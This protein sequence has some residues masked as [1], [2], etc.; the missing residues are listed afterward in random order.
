MFFNQ[1][2]GIIGLIFLGL[3]FL[4]LALSLYIVPLKDFFFIKYEKIKLSFCDAKANPTLTVKFLFK[5]RTTS[6]NKPDA[7]IARWVRVLKSGKLLYSCEGCLS[8]DS[9]VALDTEKS[10]F[11]LAT[12]VSDD[13]F[14]VVP[15][16]HS[17]FAAKGFINDVEMFVVLNPSEHQRGLKI[18]F[19]PENLTKNQPLDISF[20]N[21]R[22]EIL[23]F[24]FA[25]IA[26]IK[27]EI[28]AIPY[29]KKIT[30][31]FLI[32]WCF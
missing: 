1:R 17:S 25:K 4:T 2:P 12:Q 11:G 18:F 5:D 9:C 10:V 8:G 28:I 13:F 22:G 19:Q 3:N 32:I 21:D 15:W 6:K 20:V 29:T 7:Q 27:N 23:D 24:K 31:L 16:Y 30:P 14:S 26:K